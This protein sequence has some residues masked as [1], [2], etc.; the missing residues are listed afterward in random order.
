MTSTCVLWYVNHARRG[1]L[2]EEGGGGEEAQEAAAV[3]THKQGAML[4]TQN[5]SS[6]VMGRSGK[7]PLEAN[8]GKASNSKNIRSIINPGRKLADSPV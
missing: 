1:T 4:H 2:L 3:E 5:L 8:A 6:P 7:M